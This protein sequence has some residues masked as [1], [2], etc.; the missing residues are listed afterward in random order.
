M[1]N[2]WLLDPVLFIQKCL[3]KNSIVERGNLVIFNKDGK[4]VY[5]QL[6]KIQKSHLNY[7]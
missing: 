1:Y 2:G 4:K 3:K 7:Y 6:S 5:I